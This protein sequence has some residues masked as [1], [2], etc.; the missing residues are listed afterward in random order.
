VQLLEFKNF[1][2]L[3]A[4][5]TV[6]GLI[7]VLRRRRRKGMLLRLRGGVNSSRLGARDY[8][9]LAQELRGKDK[10][11]PF[12]QSTQVVTSPPPGERSLNVV[13]NYNGETW[14][15][16]EVLGLPAGSGIDSVDSA[17]KEMIEKVDLSSK[18]FI[19]AAARAIRNHR[20]G[21]R[22]S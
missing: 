1:L 8:S 19:E 21:R 14:D 11:K 15:A 18:P 17:C 22:V 13:F 10:E 2:M 5:L 6:A 12:L 3:Y 16:Y 9:S 20:A 4:G 7:F